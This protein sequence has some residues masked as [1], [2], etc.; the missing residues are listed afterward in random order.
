MLF[1]VFSTLLLSVKQQSDLFAPVD[2]S[3]CDDSVILHPAKDPRTDFAA[4]E[5]RLLR[6]VTILGERPV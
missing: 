5:R 1:P 6:R 4:G 2:T 3:P